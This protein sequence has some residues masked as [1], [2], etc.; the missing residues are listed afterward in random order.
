MIFWLVTALLAVAVAGLAVAPLLRAAPA[1]KEEPNDVALYRD[2]LAEIDRDLARGTIGPDEAE[3]ARTEVARRL[4]S[5]DRAA[6]PP[7]TDAPR[8]VSRVTAGLAALVLA[9]GG[10][11]LYA[12]LGSPDILDQP[13][14]ARLARAADLQ[15]N[16]MTQAEA[17]ALA[18]GT[19][20]AGPAEDV[21]QDYLDMVAQL[22]ELMPTRPDDLEGW[23]LLARH[24]ALLGD[25][26]AA[27]QA[28]GHVL[29]I[30]GDDATAA[31]RIQYADLLV[32]A[33][34]GYVSRE[35]EQV[36]RGVYEARPDNAGARF[37]LGLFY[38]QTDRPDLAF[39]LWRPVAEAGDPSAFHTDLARA[40]IELVAEAAGKNY[41]LPERSLP[42][43]LTPEG[44]VARLSDRLATQ[45]GPAPDWARLITSLVVLGDTTQANAVLAE[46]RRVFSGSA[47]AQAVLDQAA[48]DAGL[49]E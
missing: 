11:A 27:A 32:A 4:L 26:S 10:V 33:A 5:A 3:P 13:L 34:Q 22:R 28:Q 16:R 46:A 43:G 44:M 25:Y 17:E 8:A 15:A 47:E 30:L 37:T 20:D 1:P 24:E 12:L 23:R 9:G 7:L 2:Q 6:A 49:A 18:T 42:P 48:A 45:G 41:S 21:P 14:A 38:A 19:G 36:V 39:E 35:A 40:Q 29:E 31:E